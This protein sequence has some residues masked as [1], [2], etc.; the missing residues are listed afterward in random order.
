M[1]HLEESL[2]TADADLKRLTSARD[3]VI[4][5]QEGLQSE[6]KELIASMR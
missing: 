5:T 6:L 4:K 2:R 1:E 3:T